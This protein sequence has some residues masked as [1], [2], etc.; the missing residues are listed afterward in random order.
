[1]NVPA[2]EAAERTDKLRRK[3]FKARLFARAIKRTNERI[4]R[5]AATEGAEFIVGPN[6]EVVALAPKQGCADGEGDISEQSEEPESRADSPIDCVSQMTLPQLKT[7]KNDLW[8]LVL[9]NG[10]EPNDF[11]FFLAGRCGDLHFVTNLAIQQGL[12]DRRS[13]RD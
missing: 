10:D 12:A 9:V 1:M 6:G 7:P 11:E 13:R 8:L 5:E 2:R 4:A 3:D